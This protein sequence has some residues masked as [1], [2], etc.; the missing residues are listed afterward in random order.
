MQDIFLSILSNIVW[1]LLGFIG[2]KL[3]HLVQVT[4][5]SRRIWKLVE[6]KNIVLCL[7]NSSITDTGEY[8]R[9][10]TG[11]GQVRALAL[12]V[13]SLNKAYGKIDFRNVFLSTDQMHDFLESDLI[14]LGG[15]KNNELTA[16][17]LALMETFQPVKMKGSTLIWRKKVAQNWVDDEAEEFH[18]LTKEGKVVSDYGLIMKTQSP[19]TSQDRTAVLIAGSHTFGTV[20]AAKFLTENLYKEH[21]GE[22]NKRN[23]ILLVSAQVI[24]GYPTSIKLEKSYSW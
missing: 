19:F 10:A 20:A 8:N 18:G 14:L 5:P 4:I 1:L 15:A 21:K 6:P 13:T 3:L 17:Y 12:I 11:I 16:R 9:P 23:V 24:S 22:L 7:S 2:V